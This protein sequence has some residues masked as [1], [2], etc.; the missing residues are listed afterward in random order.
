MLE[1]LMLIC[2]KLQL[3][4]IN[5]MASKIKVIMHPMD[6]QKIRSMKEELDLLRLSHTEK[7]T[8]SLQREQ[9]ETAITEQEKAI[10]TL[11]N[12]LFY[13]KTSD[14]YLEE[15]L[16]A[17]QK[18][19]AETK[20][21]LIRMDHLLDSLEDTAE[22]NIDRMEED[23]SLMIL[24]L[25]PS[26]QPIYT[27]LKGSLN[28]TLNLQQSIQGLHNQ[29]QLLLELVEGILSVRY[30]VKKQGILCYIFGRNPN[31]QIAQYLEAI[32][33][34]IL[35]TLETLQQYQNTLTEDDIELKALSKSA[36]I[37][38]SELLDFCKKKWNFKTIDQSL[39]QTYSVLGELLESFQTE[40]NHLKKEEQDIR[41][42]IRDW[43]ANHSA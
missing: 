22:E 30:A 18:I 26:E 20:Q 16:K 5:N 31:Q 38:Y 8:L 39:I 29:T 23:L 19:L 4:T 21:K 10:E 43:I 15:Q 7:Q 14:F 40:L 11:K 27:A 35:Q 34:V 25:Y 28:H 6:P 37:I 36:L 33:R 17:A 9:V 2:I 24:S 12:T 41:I 3:Y 42:Q 1:A 13:Q 32:Q